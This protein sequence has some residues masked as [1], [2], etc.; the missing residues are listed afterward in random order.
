MR[1]NDNVVNLKS[2]AK[3]KM[4][5]KI[6]IIGVGEIGGSI[7]LACRRKLAK[8]IVGVCRRRS[9]CIKA[10]KAKAVDMAT[11]SLKKGVKDADLIVLAAPVGEIVKLAKKTVLYAKKGALIT[12]VGSTKKYIVENIERFLPEGMK[13]VGSHPMAGSEKGGPLSAHKDLFKNRD[14]FV[15]QTRNTD[16]YALDAIKIFWKKLGAKPIKVSLTEHE[17]IVARVSQM[18]H[19]VASSLVIACRDA[20]GY[21]ASG[22]R[23][24]TRIAL[25]K[26]ELWRDICITNDKEIAKSLS[27]LINVLRKFRSA[28][29]RKD[30]SAIE[31][32]LRKA[33]DLRE[34]LD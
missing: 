25:A 30:A 15:A 4:F 9:S 22:F 8:K 34:K 24:T 6:A 2:S 29:S 23:D 14:C 19:V 16:K 33:K 26:P 17:K 32:M 18:V 21:A 7:G 28:I 1:G 3:K 13:F 5:K 31:A 10:L 20:L 27:E 11:L 12:D